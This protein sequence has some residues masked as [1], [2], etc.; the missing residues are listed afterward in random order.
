MLNELLILLGGP[1]FQEILY[2]IFMIL[3]KNNLISNMNFNIINIFHKNLLYFNFLP[4]IP[5]DGSKLL[6]LLLEKIFPYKKSNIILVIISFISIFLFSVFEDRVIF[7]MLSC[8]LIKSII[9]EANLINI[10]YNKF[11]LERYLNNYKFK[12]GN[13]IDSIEKIKRSKCHDIIEDNKIY[14]EK[15]YLDKYFK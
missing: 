5:L 2:I 9:E 15:E 14:S 11:L 13:L 6:I 4:I 8:I 12:K 3:Y 1:L 7:I 10:K